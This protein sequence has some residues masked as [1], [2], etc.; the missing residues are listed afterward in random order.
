MLNCWKVVLQLQQRYWGQLE[1]HLHHPLQH[2]VLHQVL[3]AG[4]GSLLNI[5]LNDEQQLLLYLQSLLHILKI[6]PSS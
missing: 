1:L 5:E 4:M 6:S 2:M 3:E